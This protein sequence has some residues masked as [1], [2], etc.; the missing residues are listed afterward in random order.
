MVMLCLISE[1]TRRV[2]VVAK[3]AVED[4]GHP[5]GCMRPSRLSDIKY[6][7]GL[8]ELVF[9]ISTPSMSREGKLSD[10]LTLIP[11]KSARGPAA[12]K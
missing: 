4:G 5:T 7:N 12:P 8:S 1:G 11:E 10:L 2:Q 3:M 6:G 9:V